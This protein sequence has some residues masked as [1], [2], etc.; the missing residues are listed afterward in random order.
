MWAEWASL[1]TQDLT[2]LCFRPL[3][4]RQCATAVT[5]DEEV[6]IS[7]ENLTG[8]KWLFVFLFILHCNKFLPHGNTHNFTHFL[9]GRFWHHQWQWTWK[10]PWLSSVP[11][12][13][14]QETEEKWPAGDHV[15]EVPARWTVA[16]FSPE[17]RAQYSLYHTTRPSSPLHSLNYPAFEKYFLH[18]R[19]Q[20]QNR[21]TSLYSV[22]S[23]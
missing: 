16:P 8:R 18:A 17:P 9:L 20:R 4:W 2:G 3:S 1:Q 13:L 12:F 7:W 5:G 6:G 21:K 14:V 22:F 15:T 11:L 10:G 23:S 19:C